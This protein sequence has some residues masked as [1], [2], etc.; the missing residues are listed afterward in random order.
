MV[1][2]RQIEPCPEKWG[3]TEI[4]PEEFSIY[5]EVTGYGYVCIVFHPMVDIAYYHAMP[6]TN[7]IP[8]LK[9]IIGFTNYIQESLKKLG[10]NLFVCSYDNKPKDTTL[11]LITK[12]LG[13]IPINNVTYVKF[14]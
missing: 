5:F 8:R 2:F 3:W 4:P 13:F 9:V 14:L 11:K 10:I 1:K 7:K 6:Y 12:H